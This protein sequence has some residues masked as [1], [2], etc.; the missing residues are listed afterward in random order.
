MKSARLLAILAVPAV[1]ALGLAG[2]GDDSS[3]GGSSS[4]PS[5]AG[6]HSTGCLINKTWTLDVADAATQIG[7]YLTT[8]G[9]AVT[10]STGAGSQTFTFTQEGH[11]T[12]S[13]N[14]TYTINV[15]ENG[16]ALVVT[17]EHTG[18]SNG[19]WAWQ[20]AASGSSSVITFANW[21]AGTYAVQN[22]IS[23]DGVQSSAPINFPDAGLGGTDMTVTCSGNH[24]TTKVA[25]SPFTQKWTAG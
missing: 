14:L 18:D 21:D 16:H 17:Q 13:T 12:A 4:A 1:V 24:L 8:K 9:L 23:I 6:G 2:C 3:G 5:A 15:D 25:A 7:D 22:T 11:A 19:D 10:S 20:A